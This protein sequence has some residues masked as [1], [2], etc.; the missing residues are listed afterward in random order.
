MKRDEF[1]K[2]LQKLDEI[3]LE[4]MNADEITDYAREHAHINILDTIDIIKEN[5]ERW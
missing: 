4:E 3:L 5:E 1:L 2:M